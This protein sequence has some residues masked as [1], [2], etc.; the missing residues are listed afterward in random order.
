MEPEEGKVVGRVGGSMPGLGG[1]QEGIGAGS[2]HIG[3]WLGWQYSVGH[4]W[5]YHGMGISRGPLGWGITV[6]KHCCSQVRLFFSGQEIKSYL[7][8][9][10]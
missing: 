5:R 1:E 4:S 8:S 6:E 3:N 2:S 7:E 9:W 10:W